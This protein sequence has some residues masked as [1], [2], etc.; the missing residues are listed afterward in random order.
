[1]GQS[2]KISTD[3]STSC[4]ESYP[5]PRRYRAPVP[6]QNPQKSS[7][8]KEENKQLHQSKQDKTQM[9]PEESEEAI[10]IV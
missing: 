5:Q 10:K 2:M 7:E 6:K 8:Q 4:Q 1:M 3:W 9:S